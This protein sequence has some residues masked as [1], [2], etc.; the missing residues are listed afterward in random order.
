MNSSLNQKTGNSFLKAHLFI[1]IKVIVITFFSISLKT[2]SCFYNK[3]HIKRLIVKFMWGLTLR[4]VKPQNISLRKLK[5]MIIDIL[6]EKYLQKLAADLLLYT[7]SH[8]ICLLFSYVPSL[9]KWNTYSHIFNDALPLIS[10][11]TQYC[12]ITLGYQTF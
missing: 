7:K 9:Q 3:A 12:A 10:E 11:I 8:R 5:S 1:H 4:M 2:L 6:A